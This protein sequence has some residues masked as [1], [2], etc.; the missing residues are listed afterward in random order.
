M[1]VMKWGIVV[2][3]LAAVLVAVMAMGWSHGTP[4]EVARAE[5]GPI[6]Q[7]V[8]ERGKTRLPRTYLITMPYN[9]RIE[10][11]GAVEG[12]SVKKGEVVARV[13]PIDLEL[14]VD[15]AKAVVGRLEAS[16]RENA[17]VALEN[18]ALK[19]AEQFVE[20]MEATVGAA[21]ARMDSGKAGYEYSEKNFNRVQGLFEAKAAAQ[22]EFDRAM[23]E[24]VQA[25]VNYR[26]DQ[27]VYTAMRALQSATN[28]LPT[29]VSQY[30]DRKRLM[31]AVLEKERAEAEAQLLQAQQA[32]QRGT[33]TSPIDGIVLERNS[34]NE[35][36]LAAGTTLLELGR[37]EDLQV[38]ADV[39][40]V[41]VVDVDAGA[42]VEI[43]G[44]AIGEPVAQGS[45]LRIYPAGFTK[46]SSLGVEQQKVKVVVE[47]KP[48]DLAR[49]RKERHLG[50]GYRVRVRII[51]ADKPQA[52]IVPRSALFRGNDGSWQLYAVD[53]GRVHV[54]T[55]QVGIVNDQAVEIASGL[56]QGEL[57]IVAPESNLS[58][59]QRV[60]GKPS[61]PP[62]AGNS[63]PS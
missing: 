8:D 63:D 18:S 35:R 46:V 29:M 42:P 47:F 25:S 20:S 56:K 44:P 48:E 17:D 52:L 28:L 55:V 2:V 6:R 59:G 54:R 30:I 27:L 50:V 45:V 10:A 15:Q 36:F 21:Q 33:M 3:V 16:L 31:G 5:M 57:V 58:E 37:L 26:Q 61:A 60:E 38:E 49:L 11:I 4:V 23:L 62:V 24:K 19:Q 7:F 1:K 43:Y 41:E 9:G 53:D 51:T 22:A 39:L 40:S 14:T 34:T 12:T 32:Q 13:V